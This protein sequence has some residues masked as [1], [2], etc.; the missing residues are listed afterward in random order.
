MPLVKLERRFPD[1]SRES[2]YQQ[3]SAISNSFYDP[4]DIGNPD[5]GEV[6]PSG[7]LAWRYPTNIASNTMGFQLPE[8]GGNPKN[9][10]YGLSNGLMAGGGG[11]AG[12]SGSAS[13][14]LVYN[15]FFEN[16]LYPHSKKDVQ[17]EIQPLYANS[18]NTMNGRGYGRGYDGMKGCG[19]N[20]PSSG[21]ATDFSRNN[22]YD[23]FPD[24]FAGG[25]TNAPSSGS[26]NDYS[27]NNPY[28]SFKPDTFAGTP[29][30]RFAPQLQMKGDGI[31]WLGFIKKVSDGMQKLPEVLD[32][33]SKVAN[34]A[35]DVISTIKKLREELKKDKG[36]KQDEDEE[37]EDSEEERKKRRRRKARRKM[38]GGEIFHSE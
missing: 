20:A 11:T 29:I 10:Y 37:S 36:V 33:G 8:H 38:K 4:R 35:T 2:T 30:Q 34:T 16:L 12:S 25:S 18:N 17:N 9:M 27:L 32:A 26:A 15:K 14:Y 23:A 3:G 13:D 28:S 19:N 22:P 6:A 5:N 7:R 21:S 1:T 24:T 31:D